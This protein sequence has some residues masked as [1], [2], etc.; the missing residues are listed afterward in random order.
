LPTRI[1]HP[2]KPA[3]MKAL[4]AAT[5]FRAQP[6]EDCPKPTGGH[7]FI[8]PLTAICYILARGFAL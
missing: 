6:P 2:Q 1:F 7:T 5:R 3:F 8:F 4:T